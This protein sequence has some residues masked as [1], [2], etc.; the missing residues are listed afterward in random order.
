MQPTSV[1]ALL[2]REQARFARFFVVGCLGFLVDAGVLQLVITVTGL[3]PLLARIGS[4]AVAVLVTFGLNRYWTFSGSQRRWAQAFVA[5]LTVQS[6]GFAANMAVYTLIIVILPHPLS[7][8]V[9]ALAAA[10]AFALSLNY[11]G[12]RSLVFSSP[13]ASKKA[14]ASILR[15]RYGD[16]LWP[17]KLLPPTDQALPMALC[18]FVVGMIILLA[19]TA[20]V[21]AFNADEFQHLEMAWL[22][23]TRAVPY[24]DF[25]EHHTPLYHFLISPLLSSRNVMTDGDDAIRLVL[26]IRV[27]GVALCACIL[28]LVSIITRKI[29]GQTEALFASALLVTSV[30]FIETGVE[31]RPDQLGALLLLISTLS[32]ML[33]RVSSKWRWYL[34]LSG[35]A[36]A[37]AV[38]TT[39]KIVLAVPGLAATFFIIFAQRRM[40]AHHLVQGCGIFA[41]SAV[42][43]AVPVLFYFWSHGALADF[44]KDNF[45][46]GAK[47][48]HDATTIGPIITQICRNDGLF[49]FLAGIGL[50]ECLR[51]KPDLAIWRLAILAP[52]FSMVL[53]MPVFPIVQRQ[54]IFLFL[55]YAAILGGIG[56]TFVTRT[57]VWPEHKILQPV[58]VLFLVVVLHGVSLANFEKNALGRNN[59]ALETL[60]YVVEQTP[61]NATVMR[62]WS[63]GVAFRRPAY[64]YFSLNSEIRHLIPD[65]SFAELR[66]GLRSG[67][68]APAVIEM[69]QDMEDMPKEIVDALTSGWEPTG[70]GILW[71]RKPK[72]GDGAQ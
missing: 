55:P 50:I 25:F 48:K 23:A 70:M 29:A 14:T 58:V 43:A 62:A 13:R 31:I 24:R 72:V 12:A 38:L 37:L 10:S 9:V 54:Y 51:L 32:L 53:F 28:M 63:A 34:V 45:L 47:W 18:V 59:V 21:R 6:T 11:V 52:L 57:L 15:C 39:Q 30:V 36:V 20:W 71:R 64:F 27:M 49:I 35:A 1:Y 60:R 5:Y 8:P 33:A 4:F 69:D 26:E 16:R 3:G 67:S 68:I 42:M 41:G 17:A 61:P 44:V 66:D 22:I 40:P 7:Q 2:A 19:W 56:M 46:L 65:T